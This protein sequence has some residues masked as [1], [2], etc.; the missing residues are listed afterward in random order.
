MAELKALLCYMVSELDFEAVDKENIKE[1]E[2]GMTKSM[3]VK[4]KAYWKR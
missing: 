2:T 3:K 4:V 1:E